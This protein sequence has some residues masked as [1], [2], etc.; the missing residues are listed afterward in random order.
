MIAISTWWWLQKILTTVFQK[1]RI[2]SGWYLVG[3]KM[4]KP[5]RKFNSIEVIAKLIWPLRL[6]NGNDVVKA[7]CISGSVPFK[8]KWNLIWYVVSEILSSMCFLAITKF[9]RKLFPLNGN[10]VIKTDMYWTD[11]PPQIIYMYQPSFSP[12]SYVVVFL[13][14][15]V[16]MFSNKVTSWP[17]P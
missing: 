7:A 16:N 1:P 4:V 6:L 11:A 12:I 9:I 14:T 10:D 17:W 15:V 3:N 2:S 5:S 13:K 8:F